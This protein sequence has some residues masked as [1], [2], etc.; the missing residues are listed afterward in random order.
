MYL[1]RQAGTT[2]NRAPVA[3]KR[4]SARYF[5]GPPPAL[6]QRRKPAE[7]FSGPLKN[8]FTYEAARV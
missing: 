1:I 4:G 2:K 5:P 7:G 6:R 8:T 3:V